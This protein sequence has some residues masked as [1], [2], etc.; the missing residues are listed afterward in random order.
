MTNEESAG[1]AVR[2]W[3][4]R[5]L[6]CHG[7]EGRGDGPLAPSLPVAPRDFRDPLFAARATERHVATAIV[8]GGAAVG[9]SKLMPAHPDLAVRPEV[10]RRLVQ[11]VRVTAGVAGGEEASGTSSGAVVPDPPSRRSGSGS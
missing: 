10:L 6:T 7:A 3:D 8:E 5:C 11:R 2:V 1:F 9:L 4:T